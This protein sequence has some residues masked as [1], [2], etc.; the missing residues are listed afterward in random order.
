MRAIPA[1]LLLPFQ[2]LTDPAFRWPLLKGLGGA[3][4]AFLALIGLADWGV[5]SL[6][7]GDGWLATLAGL[8]GGLLV[9]VSAVWL[10]V[11]VALAIAGLFLDEVAAAVEQ[12]YYPA[13]PPAEGSG[14][15]QQIWAGLKLGLQ[16]LGL[17]ILIMPLAFLLPPVGAVAFWAVAAVSLGYGLFDGVAQR[18]MSVQQSH[19]LRRQMRWS[20]LTVGAALAALS[21]VP[22][23]NLLVPVIGTAAMTHLLHRGRYVRA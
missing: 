4:L 2:Q 13:L 1:S 3:L 22:L 21:L 20:V 19:Q 17:A 6:V 14:L 9:L 11:P 16:V 10:F 7:G 18:R 23:A 12:R 5:S 15:H 8:F